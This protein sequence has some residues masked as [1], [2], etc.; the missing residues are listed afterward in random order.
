ML[1]Q[2]VELVV[3]L[4]GARVRV[5]RAQRE[6]L[7]IDR[8]P[9]E[10]AEPLG[11]RRAAVHADLGARREQLQRALLV[12]QL[13]HE[14]LLAHLAHARQQHLDADG[15][16]L[17][18]GL[19]QRLDQAIVR[20]VRVDRHDL[21]LGVPNQAIVGLADAVGARMRVGGDG[22]DG[23]LAVGLGL[24][25]R[26]AHGPLAAGALPVLEEGLADA[27]GLLAVDGVEQV[28]PA[29]HGLAVGVLEGRFQVLV[30]DVAPAGHHAAAVGDVELVVGQRRDAPAADEGGAE[31]PHLEPILLHVIQDRAIGPAAEAQPDGVHQH[32]HLEAA[33]LGLHLAL[34]RNQGIGQLAAGL[35]VVPDEGLDVEA[36]L[37]ALDRVDQGLARRVGADVELD[38]VQPGGRLQ[39]AG[40]GQ[41]GARGG[42]FRRLRHHLGLQLGQFL[43][44]HL[45][46]GGRH[47]PFGHARVVQRGVLDLPGVRVLGLAVEVDAQ[48]AA[49]RSRPAQHRVLQ[50]GTPAVGARRQQAHRARRLLGLGGI[51]LDGAALARLQG[52]GELSA[53]A[54]QQRGEQDGGDEGMAH[55][56]RFLE[57]W[58]TWVIPQSIGPLLCIQAKPG[59]R[60]G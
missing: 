7:A 41:H 58:D 53:A 39:R 9:L 23:H 19:N 6:H 16:V 22:L 36:A 15:R 17:A 59:E 20:E 54:G 4:V 57:L 26:H 45:A 30:P 18:L 56:W 46:D 40:Q 44:E 55:R 51:G 2:G 1:N 60:F 33:A 11:A 27:P 47:G 32:L 3:V 12:E 28:V 49:K 10:V 38:A 25:R 13:V 21:A 35:V 14:A 5:G 24:D 31:E 8:E 48:L 37:G 50:G 52:R 42:R 34:A 43:T 29:E